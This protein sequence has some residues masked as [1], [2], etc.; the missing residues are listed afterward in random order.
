MTCFVFVFKGHA[1]I[2][3][4]IKM[5]YGLQDV[6]KPEEERKEEIETTETTGSEEGENER[7]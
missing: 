5:R 4:Q 3:D 1:L 7:V 6:R 2:L